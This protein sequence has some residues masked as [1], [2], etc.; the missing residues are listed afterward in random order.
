MYPTTFKF[1]LGEIAERLQ[2]RIANGNE[3]ITPEKQ[4]LVALWCMATPDSYRYELLY[5]YLHC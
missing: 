5:L 2:K 1:L 3:I 4:L